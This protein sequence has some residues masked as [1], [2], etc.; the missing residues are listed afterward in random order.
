MKKIITVLSIA[1]VAITFQ[2][3]AAVKIKIR[4]IDV[5]GS[6]FTPLYDID[7]ELDHDTKT[8]QRWI[9]LEI[10]YST[11]GGWIDELSIKQLAI[12]KGHGEKDPV[13]L[14]VDV[15]YLNIGPGNHTATVYMHPNCVR[16][17]DVKAKELDSGVFFMIDGA[18]VAQEET[19]R[20]VTKGWSTNGKYTL[21]EGHLLSEADT[22]FWFVNYDFKEMIQRKPHAVHNKK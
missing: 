15:T 10:K 14:S 7:T 19:T 5:N 9:R 20:K 6:I 21:H 4:S 13:I 2:A 11:S 22:P 8:R 16:R 17:Y 12:A 1:M 3:Q 18:V